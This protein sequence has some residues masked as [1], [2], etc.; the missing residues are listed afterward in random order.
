MH[1]G[2][3]HEQ[4]EEQIYKKCNDIVYDNACD[5]SQKQSPSVVAEVIGVDGDGFCPSEPY[6]GAAYK[7]DRVEV[8]YGI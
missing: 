7:A 5:G 3:T 2:K 8:L 6:K 4:Y 1:K